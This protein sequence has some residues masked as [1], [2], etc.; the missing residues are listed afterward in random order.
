MSTVDGKY[1]V[2]DVVVAGLKK[3]G[4]IGSGQTANGS[5]I[6]DAQNDLADMLAQWNT[7]TWLVWDKV[8]AYFNADGRTTPYTVGPGGNYNV[9]PRPDRIEGAFVRILNVPNG[10]PVDQP[11]RQIPAAEGYANIA[12]KELVAF[13]KSYYYDPASPV[14]N[15]NIYPWPNAAIYGIGI[16]MKNVFPLVLPLTMSLANLPPAC[17]PAMKFNLARRLRQAYGK[18]LRPDPELNKLA[19]ASLAI[20]RAS[21]IQVPEMTMPPMLIRTGWYNIYGDISY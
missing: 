16:V 1:T 18:G 7:E 19:K 3:S 11:I 13:P 6:L 17:M 21:Q 2:N 12:L 8:I 20:I 14:G 5:D 9:T 15:L 4:I 10:I